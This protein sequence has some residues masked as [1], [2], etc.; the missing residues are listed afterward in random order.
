MK[1]EDRE[2]LHNNSSEHK[3]KRRNVQATYQYSHQ[4]IQYPQGNQMSY[5]Q[6]TQYSQV[7]YPHIQGTTMMAPP[8]PP[9]PTQPPRD[10]NSGS[11][12]VSQLTNSTVMGGRNEQLQQR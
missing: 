2:Y 12:A 3:A 7:S 8:P 6:S 11:S 5:P 4:Y 1:K 9:P 10:I